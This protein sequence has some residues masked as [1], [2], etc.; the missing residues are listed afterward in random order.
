M[1]TVT[2]DKSMSKEGIKTAISPPIE[3]LKEEFDRKYEANDVSESSEKL[4]EYKFMSLLGKGAFGLVVC[5]RVKSQVKLPVNSNPF[6]R[7]LSNTSQP[8]NSTL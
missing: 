5:H 3:S 1:D 4:K 8:T 2:D 6:L 7:N